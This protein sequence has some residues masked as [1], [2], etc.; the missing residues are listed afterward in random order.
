MK[1]NILY[2]LF[3]LYLYGCMNPAQ[4][5]TVVPE[6]R[7][8]GKELLTDSL[9]MGKYLM[10][11][12]GD[13]MIMPSYLRD[14]VMYVGK[15]KGD[16]LITVSGFLTCGMGPNEISSSFSVARCCF[17]SVLTFLDCNGG[18]MNFVYNIPV[19]ED[20]RK[21]KSQWKRYTFEK[22]VKYRSV[23]PALVSLSDTTLLLGAGTYD[24]PYILSIVNL[25]TQEIT[26]VDF[27]PDGDG[28]ECSNLV[29]QSVYMD[30]ARLYKNGDKIL[31][32]CGNAHYA[33]LFELNGT[34]I[35][36]QKML[37][38]IYPKYKMHDDGR[39]YNYVSGQCSALRFFITQQFI[40][41]CVLNYDRLKKEPYKGYP[42]AFGD[43]VWVFDWEGN[44]IKNYVTDTPFEF[45]VV[46]ANDEVMYTQT[47]DL[48]TD[49]D[50]LRSYRLK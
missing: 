14:S 11:L 2:I 31:Y 19:D 23:F 20:G 34:K 50:L 13:E 16:S 21:D 5:K 41:V 1:K 46:D 36:N 27:W 3:C 15:I 35:V 7:L 47:V 8:V 38:D 9:Y 42:Y 29:R 32:S 45:F 30:N 44:R 24:E 48:D 39:N 10:H 6:V 18:R 4:D 28:V 22:V 49:E 40:Y 33:F 37:F 43:E 25:K 26:P 12:I 17:D